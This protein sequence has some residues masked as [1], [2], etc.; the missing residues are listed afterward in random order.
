M[1]VSAKQLERAR[2][3]IDRAGQ[4]YCAQ[5]KI[6]L[7]DTPSPLYRLL[8]LS[9][10]LAKPIAGDLAVAGCVELG[11]AGLRAPRA[12]LAATWQQRVD[13][14]SRAHY[15]RYDESTATRLEQSAQ[16]LLDHYGGDL[17]RLADHADSDPDR[18]AEL[19]T[20]VPG[21]GPSGASIFLREAQAVW[22]WLRPYVD[23][24]MVEGARRLG[25]PRSRAGLGELLTRL[26]PAQLA[27][28]LV[29]ASLDDE[30]AAEVRRVA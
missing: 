26:Q 5:A 16:F 15:R 4:T 17:R 12:M 19:L 3:A 22:L 29:R 7:K 1:A 10:L 25:L 6:T 18:A 13:A 27:A 23:E 20:E 28:A 9:T 8:V 21:I 14:L 24:R 30:L 11:R 2:A